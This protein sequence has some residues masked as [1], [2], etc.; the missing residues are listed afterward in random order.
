MNCPSCSQPMTLLRERYEQA[1]DDP[2][3]EHHPHSDA[4][5]ACQR[6]YAEYGCEACQIGRHP[7]VTD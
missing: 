1:H 4:P 2:S 6:T 7:E 3:C 5:K